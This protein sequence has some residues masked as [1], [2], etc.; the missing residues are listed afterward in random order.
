MVLKS[1][2]WPGNSLEPY[3][4]ARGALSK[5]NR[6]L[7]PKGRCCEDRGPTNRVEN[8]RRHL[9]PHRQLIAVQ[10][11]KHWHR[12]RSIILRVA[13]WGCPSSGGM[14][15][16]TSAVPT[17]AWTGGVSLPRPPRACCAGCLIRSSGITRRG[18]LPGIRDG[19]HHGQKQ[20]IQTPAA[21]WLRRMVDA[22]DATNGARHRD[23]QTSFRQPVGQWLE[24]ASDGDIAGQIPAKQFI[25][26][27][28]QDGQILTAF[29]MLAES[30]SE[31]GARLHR[32]PTQ[33]PLKGG[34]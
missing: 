33:M 15:R 30:D 19:A 1:Q 28:F 27:G 6:R 34:L 11:R 18:P 7:S 14:T 23:P 5:S 13:R 3:Q 9:Y 20:S 24:A 26:S 10:C 32:T 8:W 31:N 25:V 16:A 22:K 21:K 12:T 29:D 2:V 4:R 17:M